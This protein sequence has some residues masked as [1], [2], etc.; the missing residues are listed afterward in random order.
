MY[1]MSIEDPAGFW[2]E[3][4]AQFYWKCTWDPS[5]YSG[6][7]DV[8][9]GNV[10]IKWFE[11]GITNICYNCLDRHIE[12]GNGDKIV[13]C[14][15]GNEPGADASLTYTQLL[16]RDQT[17][18]V[19]TGQPAGGTLAQYRFGWKQTLLAVGL[20]AISGAGTSLVFMNAVVPRLKSWIRKVRS[21]KEEDLLKKTNKET[22]LTAADVARASQ[23]MLIFTDG[24]YLL[25]YLMDTEHVTTFVADIF[26]SMQS[27]HVVDLIVHM[28]SVQ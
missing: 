23:D 19:S 4:A 14:W 11:G 7:L 20:L 13:I 27:T 16:Q 15:E 12:S 22:S 3:I 28:A 8:R 25:P 21:E 9:K 6:N 1:K 2:S 18:P 24:G 26:E 5:V 10:N 17:P